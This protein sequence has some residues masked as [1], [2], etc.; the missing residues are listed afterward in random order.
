MEIYY[1]H[2]LETYHFQILLIGGFCPNWS[3][4]LLQSKSKFQYAFSKY[5]F[6]SIL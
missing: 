1:I 5:K 3:V 4:D 6:S 2:D